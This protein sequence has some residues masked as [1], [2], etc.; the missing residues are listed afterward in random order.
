MSSINGDQQTA[1]AK[2]QMSIV[3][4]LLNDT[5]ALEV[6]DKTAAGGVDAV[7]AAEVRAFGFSGIF[8][9]EP[10]AAGAVAG[11]VRRSF[12]F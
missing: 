6:F 4:M 8:L 9:I 5:A 12:G 7:T 11:P 2:C 10:A 3:D 1:A